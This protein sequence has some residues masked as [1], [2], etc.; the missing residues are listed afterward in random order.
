MAILWIVW[1]FSRSV[2]GLGLWNQG[3]VREVLEPA[4]SSGFLVA[5]FCVSSNPG[6]FMCF[7]RCSLCHLNLNA[8]AQR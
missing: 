2:L 6:V 1:V 5:L 3:T 8:V 4:G 7:G